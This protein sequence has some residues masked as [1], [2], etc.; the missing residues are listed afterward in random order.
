MFDAKGLIGEVLGLAGIV[1][2]FLF[3]GLQKN[4]NDFS[5]TTSYAFS[6]AGLVIMETEQ[7]ARGER[8]KIVIFAK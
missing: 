1:E 2:D 5:R 3:P 8:Y 4:P 6:L 7:M